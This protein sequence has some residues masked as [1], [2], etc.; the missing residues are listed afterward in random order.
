[1]NP[2]VKTPPIRKRPPL[3]DWDALRRYRVELLLGLALAAL[4]LFALGPA[5]ACSF[6]N[7]DDDVF[8]TENM[9]VLGGLSLEGTAWAFT[10]RRAN[11][12]HPLTWLSLQ[13]DMD[14]FAGSPWGFHATNLLLHLGNVLLLFALL[15]WTTGAAWRS[16]LAAALF[17]V[18]P[19]HVESVAWVTE[20]KDV[21]SMFL[22]LLTTLAYVGFVCRPG[23]RR[24]AGVVLLYLLGLLAKPVLLTL[25][26]TLLLLDWWPL[27][28][29][30]V[31]AVPKEGEPAPAFPPA[32]LSRLVLEKVPL[33]LVALAVGVFNL[34][35]RRGGAIRSGEYLGLAERL[36]YTVDA[37]AGYLGK[38]VRP[39]DLAPFYPLRPGGLPAERVVASALVLGAL[40]LVLLALAR[41][42]PYLGVGWLWYLGTLVPASGI[43]QLGSYALADRYTYVPSVGLFVAFVWG[44]AD[45]FHRTVPV[46]IT[47]AAAG[48]VLL[49]LALMCR[50]QVSTW[51]NSVALWEHALAVTPDNFVARTKLGSAYEEAG[52]LGDAVTQFEAAALLR[53]DVMLAQKDLGRVYFRLGRFAEAAACFRRAVA[54]KPDDGHLHLDLGRA[55][56]KAGQENAAAEEFRIAQK[57]GVGAP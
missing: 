29:W 17:A 45:L 55:L 27:R 54:L 33:F 15:R 51:R 39:V 23:W 10:T 3:V 30:P 20:R 11:N 21:L 56:R 50:Q 2:D 57:L 40:T 13:L 31:G 25:P 34:Y 12:W 18:H 46:R 43:V 28:R 48:L 16:A 52:R 8:V 5:C 14:L 42:R 53:P 35:Q 38:L 44:M 7:Y 24:Y 1:V 36:G 22:W 32:P 9:N 37:Y 41:R 47:A 4:T 6:V 49:A 19:M 26:A